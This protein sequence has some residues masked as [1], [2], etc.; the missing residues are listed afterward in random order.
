MSIASERASLEAQIVKK[1]LKND[2][3]RRALIDDPKATI[4]RECG[5]ELPAD[6]NINV[7]P[8]NKNTINLV[9]PYAAGVGADIAAQAEPM[10]ADC[11]GWSSFAEC[12]VEC[13]QCGNNETSC[14]PGDSEG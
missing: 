3:F 14:Q 9:I 11:S 5:V 13:T 10:A 8:E 7:Y 4:E 1:A 2:D 12:T 6:L